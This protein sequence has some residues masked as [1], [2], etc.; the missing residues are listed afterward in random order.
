MCPSRNGDV[1]EASRTGYTIGIMPATLRPFQ[2]TQS[3]RAHSV[4]D[5][6]WARWLAFG[7][8]SILLHYLI[9][10]WALDQFSLIS[11]NPEQAQQPVVAYLT[12][13]IVNTIQ[14]PKVR[15]SYA[16]PDLP[17]P[18]AKPKAKVQPKPIPDSLPI[19]E[20]DA[21]PPAVVPRP[22]PV[23]TS[24]AA[25]SLP[26]AAPSPLPTPIPPEKTADHLPLYSVNP[27]PP[28][29][30]S[31][32]VHATRKGSPVS[33]RARIDWQHDGK[34]YQL[35]GETSFLIFTLLSFDSV[36]QFDEAGLAPN[37]YSE[38]RVGRSA[39][40]THFNRP[41][42]DLP[43]H[44]SNGD[45]ISFSASSAHFPRHA[46]A[47]DR[48][49]ILWQLAGIARAAPQQVSAGAQFSVFVA[50]VRD[51]EIWKIAVL[52][53]E[54]LQMDGQSYQAWHFQRL[55]RAGSYEQKLD[56]W[57]APEQHWYPVRLLYT[58]VNG[59]ILEL[60]LNRIGNA[61]TASSS[62]DFRTAEP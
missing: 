5:L 23:S 13:P 55:P 4:K 56:I 62:P 53:L 49:S 29:Q 27:P 22:E 61:P 45:T 14:P 42:P 37:Q 24:A 1:I 15:V 31:Y 47:Q 26:D 50:G 25:I 10:Q 57:L 34:Q 39:T 40:N 17:E 20:A 46:G 30:L 2:V 12:A 18:V 36:G 28:V 41:K 19:A 59:D 3:H 11:F 48:A 35:R 60:S 38:K 51:A 33:G 32:S 7:G 44:P 6:P 52:G 43:A 58:E 54:T 21:P 16:H 9:L 8:L